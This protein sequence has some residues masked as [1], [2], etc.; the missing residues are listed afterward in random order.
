MSLQRI[1]WRLIMVSIGFVA[2]VVAS[3]AVAIAGLGVVA[4]AEHVAAAPDAVG[5]VALVTRAMRGAGIAP[6]LATVVWP[7]WLIAGVLGEVARV[8]G[9]VVHLVVAAAIVVVGIVG[10]APLV[11][12]ATLQIAVATGFVAGFVYWLFAGRSAG[13]VGRA[14]AP[15]EGG[16]RPPHA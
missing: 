13:L 12:V 11:G 4:S 1:L 16:P 2:A 9:L 6:I 10:T 8:R 15:V 7:G 3:V 5:V 14:V